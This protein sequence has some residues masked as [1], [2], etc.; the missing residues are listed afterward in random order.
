[1]SEIELSNIRK[2]DGGLLLVF[3]ELLR[4]RNATQAA[5]RLNLSQSAVSHSLRRLRQLFDDP[6][7]I[8]LPHGFEPTRRALALS[9]RIEALVDLAAET[10]I[11]EGG[12]N[13]ERSER[14]F[15]ISAPEFLTAMIGA[16]MAQ[17]VQNEA[18]NTSLV[19]VHLV[20]ETA[21][22]LLRRGESDIAVGRFG[23]LERRGF[24]VE[25]LFDDH[26][27]VVAR[28][29]HPTIDGSIDVDTYVSV[30]HVFAGSVSEGNPGET[31]PDPR[32]VK[33]VVIVP[34]WLTALVM[35]SSSDVISSCPRRLA[36]RVASVLD[37][38]VLDAP[39]HA[40]PFSVS[41]V[42]RSA[43]EDSGVDWLVEQVRQASR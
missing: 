2:L 32:E 13:P 6:L 9:P 35:V 33:T 22:D 23:A 30:S 1:M 43:G 34:N 24:E 31:I 3:R 29:G 17:M 14:R 10:L 15:V 19:F 21:L 16:A 5:K 25:K 28:R 39:Y 37:L 20:H 36:E 4:C 40:P 11:G 27:C 12:F 7:F 41:V 18:P 42:Q 38:Q 26:Y 8:R